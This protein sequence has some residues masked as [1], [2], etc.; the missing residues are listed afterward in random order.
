M[1]DYFEEESRR[2]N[3]DSSVEQTDVDSDSTLEQ[4]NPEG[5]NII[6]ELREL[7]N[8][9]SALELSNR[10]LN[11]NL[12]I[13]QHEIQQLELQIEELRSLYQD[14]GSAHRDYIDKSFVLPKHDGSSI[15]DEL[16][17]IDGINPP[18]SDDTP[19]D[20]NKPE[21]TVK[22]VRNIEDLL[23]KYKGFKST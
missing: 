17:T 9:I 3:D 7:R 15:M 18:G 21:P 13:K 2:E 23:E 5:Y 19:T 10:A 14:F 1:D 6:S 4:P 12:L 8:S 11:E 22:K 20:E 16:E